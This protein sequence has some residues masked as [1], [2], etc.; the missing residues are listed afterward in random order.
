MLAARGLD[1]G[2]SLEIAIAL[3][4]TLDA[5]HGLRIIHKDIKPHNVMIDEATG[6]PRL[7]DFGIAAGS[8]T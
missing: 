1:V 2:A 6:R 7:I 8:R 4:T 5:L 3:S